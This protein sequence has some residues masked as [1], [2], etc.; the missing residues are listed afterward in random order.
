M[1]NIIVMTTLL[2]LIFVCSLGQADVPF[3][4]KKS[5]DTNAYPGPLAVDQDGGLYYATFDGDNSSLYYIPDP[6][7][8]PELINHVLV[9]TGSG[10]PSGSGSGF[11][12]LATFGDYVYV[13]GE[14]LTSSV[15][16]KFLK[17]SD[18]PT[19]F[20]EVTAFAP[21]LTGKRYSGVAVLTDSGTTVAV[22]TRFGLVDLL[23]ASDGSYITCFAGA[24][25]YQRDL[26]VD[27]NGDLFCGRNGQNDPSAVNKYDWAGSGY[28]FT[29]INDYITTGAIDNASGE[30]LQG[31]G[32]A[33]HL[34]RLLIA[35][36]TAGSYLPGW[37]GPESV[38]IMD[39]VS[40]TTV[41]QELTTGPGFPEPGVINDVGDIAAAWDG[42]ADI[43]YVSDTTQNLIYVFINHIL[44][45]VKDW[46]LFK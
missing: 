1:K 40:T 27:K 29:V 4:H 9:Y 41:I 38:M 44:S 45:D 33:P 18:T 42:E 26:T 43:I 35:R 15:F 13:C 6:I 23:K 31:I 21:T 8:N 11:Q 5:I 46:R 14:T 32:Y 22:T 7:H 2:L 17:I 20:S 37:N 12:G 30:P 34:D 3:T 36:R 19:S 10:F 25:N 28:S 39:T 24:K 16:K